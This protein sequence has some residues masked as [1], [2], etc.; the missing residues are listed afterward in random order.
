M[1]S[2]RLSNAG[3]HDWPTGDGILLLRVFTFPLFF[4]AAVKAA[5][6]YFCCRVPVSRTTGKLHAPVRNSSLIL[7]PGDRPG[8]VIIFALATVSSWR[9]LP[10]GGYHRASG[11]RPALPCGR[12]CCPGSRRGRRTRSGVGGGQVGAGQ[13][14]RRPC[15]FGTGTAGSPAFGAAWASIHHLSVRAW[16]ALLKAIGCFGIRG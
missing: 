9:W 13:Q 1:N 15:S 14:P 2:Y 3:L 11:R 8:G 4:S 12:G 7:S 16:S 5:G 6:C 10:S